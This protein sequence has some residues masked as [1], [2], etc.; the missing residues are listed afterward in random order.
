MLLLFLWAS[1]LFLLIAFFVR[2]G[3]VKDST[4]QNN[5]L[6]KWISIW[7]NFYQID[8]S[9]FLSWVSNLEN[10]LNVDLQ[11]VFQVVFHKHSR[12]TSGELLSN[13]GGLMWGAESIKL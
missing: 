12:L 5:W 10:A 3:F 13:D 11:K 7:Q 8:R 9:G 4:F 6:R 1:Y 2:Q